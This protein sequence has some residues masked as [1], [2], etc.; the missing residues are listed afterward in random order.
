M[1]KFKIILRYVAALSFIS[2]LSSCAAGS[3]TAGYALKAREADYL[4]AAGEE[5]ITRRIKREMAFENCCEMERINA[6]I[7]ENY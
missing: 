2:T 6:G 3:A 7:Q 4:S 5:R 1:K